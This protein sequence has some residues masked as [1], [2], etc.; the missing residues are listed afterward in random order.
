M[1]L[2]DGGRSRILVADDHPVVRRGIAALLD[3]EPGLQVCCEAG[4]L[5]ETLNVLDE[6]SPDLLILDLT[7]PEGDALGL[8][9]RIRS[10]H[11]DLPV[12]VCSMH[13]EGIFAERA[14]RAGANGYITK[15][16]A[17]TQL[18]HAIRVVLGGGT[19]LS[20]E[21]HR[22]L[23]RER[24]GGT[25]AGHVSPVARLS[26]RELEVF[27]LIGR[28]RTTSEVA[29]SLHL[30][31]KTIETHRE[32]IKRKLGLAS[33]AE[34]TRSAVSWVLRQELDEQGS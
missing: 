17:S 20:E 30:S 33:A 22:Q 32:K 1:N 3:G 16:A 13:D 14:L 29:R 9:R 24:R 12:L 28:G 8:L 11:P 25:G 21:A 6:R 2:D 4:T 7:F 27:G 5:G 34:L 10:H 23:G 18:L 31:V 19:Y 26:D 15:Q